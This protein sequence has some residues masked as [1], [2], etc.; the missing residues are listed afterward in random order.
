MQESKR[1]KWQMILLTVAYIAWCIGF[2]YFRIAIMRVDY[3]DKSAA[4]RSKLILFTVS[5]PFTLLLFRLFKKY[6]S[7]LAKEQEEERQGRKP[8]EM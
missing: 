7:A 2:M 6:V 8:E 1:R 5:I 4:M 3:A